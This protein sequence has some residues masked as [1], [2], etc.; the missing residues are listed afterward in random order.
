MS[1]ELWIVID[2]KD[3]AHGYF[4][5][6]AEAMKKAKSCISSVVEVRRVR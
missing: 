4:S 6:K 5:T 2:W 1:E 3:G